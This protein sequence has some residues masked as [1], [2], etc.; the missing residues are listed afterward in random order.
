MADRYRINPAGYRAVMRDRSTQAECLG[1]AQRLALMAGGGP[2][3]CDV[4]PGRNRAHARVT[5]ASDSAFFRERARS[6]LAT[7][8]GG[9]YGRGADMVGRSVRSRYVKNFRFSSQGRGR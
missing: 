2:Y 1:T 9:G 8:V 6:Y 7:V 3:T 4:I 5:T